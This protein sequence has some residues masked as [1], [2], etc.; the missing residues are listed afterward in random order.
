MFKKMMLLLNKKNRGF[1]LI[2]LIVVIGILAILA[3]LAIPAVSGYLENSKARTNV[4]NAKIIYNAAQAYLAANPD[5]APGDIA[6][7][8]DTAIPDDSPIITEGYLAAVPKTAENND[9]SIIDTSGVLTVEWKAETTLAAE[10]PAGTEPGDGDTLSYPAAP[11]AP[12]AT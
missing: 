3:A 4:S 5:K 11:A 10:N 9:Y 2:E 6:T 12:P 8:A 7:G 1:T